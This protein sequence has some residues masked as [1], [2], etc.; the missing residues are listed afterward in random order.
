MTTQPQLPRAVAPQEPCPQLQRA[1]MLDQVEKR[2]RGLLN[3]EHRRWRTADARGAGIVESLAEL[4]AVGADRVRPVILLTG[5]LA[6]GGAPEAPEAVEAAAALELLDT[7]TLIRSDVRD[8]AALR[9]GIPT[10]H[11]SRA[12]EHERNGWAGE[13]RR[14]GESTATLAGDLA[15]SLGDR[16]AARLPA[17]AWQLWDEMRTERV[18]GT[19]AHEAMAAEYLDDP[20]PGRCISGCD[21]GCTAGWYA[22]RHPL[23]LGAALA[24]RTDL[25]TAYDAYAR[26]LHAAWRLRGFLDGGPEYDWDA[27]L[28]REILLEREERGIAERLIRELVD[29]ASRTAASSR[30]AA[31]WCEE[32]TAFAVRMAA[33]RG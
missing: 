25:D 20:W 31:G 1:G 32:L 7:C 29:R 10:L 30:L 28:L 15:L 21:R 17:A 23:R 24:G 12:A 9:R 14:F 18:I 33:E 16:L 11:V 22:L 13:A 6:A 8:N 26:S 2:L 19:Y 27:E 3:D 4:V 5:Y